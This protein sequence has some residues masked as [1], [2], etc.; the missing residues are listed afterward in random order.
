[1]NVR[2]CMSAYSFALI[3]L[4]VRSL[5]EQGEMFAGVSFCRTSRFPEEALKCCGLQLDLLCLS[6]AEEMVTHRML[7][8]RL[9]CPQLPFI[10]QFRSKWVLPAKERSS[11]HYPFAINKG[12]LVISEVSDTT[13]FREG[14]KASQSSNKPFCM[15]ERTMMWY[16]LLRQ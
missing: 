6:E 13:N 12:A 1:M 16:E 15:W 5:A 4:S 11:H 10:T 2:T 9:P 7:I 3:I 8:T 14:F